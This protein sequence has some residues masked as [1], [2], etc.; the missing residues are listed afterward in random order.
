MGIELRKYIALV[1]VSSYEQKE[2]NISIPSQIDQIQRYCTEHKLE[3]VK[4]Y[5]EENSAYK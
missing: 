1:R 3:L 4:I 5:K 2:R